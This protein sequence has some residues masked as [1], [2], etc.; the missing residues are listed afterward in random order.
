MLWIWPRLSFYCEEKNL[1]LQELL[2]LSKTSSCFYVSAVQVLLKK[3]WEKEKLLIK[4]VI[5]PFPSI[6]NPLENFFIKVNP[7]RNDKF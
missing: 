4:Q 3:L 6:S 1:I 5:Y 7:F 2:T